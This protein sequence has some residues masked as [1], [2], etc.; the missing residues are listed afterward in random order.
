MANESYVSSMSNTTQQ[1]HL[2]AVIKSFNQYIDAYKEEETKQH[3]TLV[4]YTGLPSNFEPKG[5]PKDDVY[6]VGNSAQY[7][8]IVGKL[9]AN[10]IYC[11]CLPTFKR[12]YYTSEYTGNTA[13]CCSRCGYAWERARK[14]INCH[15]IRPDGTIYDLSVACIECW[16]CCAKVYDYEWKYQ[17]YTICCGDATIDV[18]NAQVSIYR[19]YLS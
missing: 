10:G 8:F 12:C 6:F 16:I 7:T 14:N 1:V 2:N 15:E 11:S 5:N 13:T 17:I 4:D 18:S 3:Y 9:S 19:K